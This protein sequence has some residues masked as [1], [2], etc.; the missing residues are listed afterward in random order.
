MNPN[1]MSV[2]R[3]RA[4]RFAL[5][6]GA[7]VLGTA[8]LAGCNGLQHPEDFPVDGPKATVTSNPAEVSKDDLGH[9]WNLTVDHGTVACEHN[10]DGDPV[11]TLTAPD[12]TVYALNAVDENKDLPDIEEISD[13]SIGTL[14]TVAFTA[15]DA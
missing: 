8:G 2:P 7:L 14:R 3:H 11:L 4:V 1:T 12:G 6:A 10:K 15:C 5:A 9:S 13:G